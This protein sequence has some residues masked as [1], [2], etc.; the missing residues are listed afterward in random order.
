MREGKKLDLFVVLNEIKSGL[1]P[2][3]ISKKY[4]IPKQNI[5]YF[6]VKL[7]KAGCIQKK[8]YGVWEFKRDLKQVKDLTIRQYDKIPQKSLTSLPKKEIRGH[9][10]IW[11]IQFFDPVDWKKAVDKYLIKV[12]L[13]QKIPKL[14]FQF[15]K[16]NKQFRTIFQNR[17]IWLGK[18]GMTIYEAMDFMGRSSFETKGTAVFEMDN[19]IKNFLQELD[20]KFRAYKFTT[21][22]EHYGIIKNELARQFND[23][24][25]KMEIRSEDGDVWMWIDDSKSLGELENKNPMINRQVQKFWND[26]KS[27]DFKVDATFILNG[28]NETTKGIQANTQHLE[29]HAKNMRDHVK[30]VRILG[31]AVEKLTEKVDQLGTHTK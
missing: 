12:H 9:A 20:L 2:A 19:L 31:K 4:Q 17:K 21:S 16:Y 15:M 11:K 25:E 22:R 5:S 10:F 8:G 13:K 3:K 6:V 30:A 29:Y 26:H 14:T 18:K 1:S 24:K 28:F 23:K 27:N 7:K